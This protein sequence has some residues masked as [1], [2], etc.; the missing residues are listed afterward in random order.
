MEDKGLNKISIHNQSQDVK[1]YT[2]KK[3]KVLYWCLCCLL[4]IDQEKATELLMEI[5]NRSAIA[6][7]QRYWRET[8]PSN[9]K[10][11]GDTL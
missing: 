4:P 7:L 6:I 10:K 11:K 5:V 1:A 3:F 9:V 2:Q 8:D